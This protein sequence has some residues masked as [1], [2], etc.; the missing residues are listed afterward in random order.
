MNE[1]ENSLARVKVIRRKNEINGTPESIVHRERRKFVAESYGNV[2]RRKTMQR[3][4]SC[5]RVRFAMHEN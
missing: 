5:I 4:R 3:Q 2:A 1:K